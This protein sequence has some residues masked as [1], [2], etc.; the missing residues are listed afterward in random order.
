MNGQYI[1]RK[2]KQMGLKK[3][4][5]TE[6]TQLMAKAKILIFTRAWGSCLEVL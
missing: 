2:D 4:A 1:L 3:M 6:K 5:E